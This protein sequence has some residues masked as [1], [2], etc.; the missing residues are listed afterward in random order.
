MSILT[1]IKQITS[2][3]I[4]RV[5]RLNKING[6]KKTIKS[7]RTRYSILMR[8]RLYSTIR[9]W[10]YRIWPSL[11]SIS[12]WSLMRWSALSSNSHLI[13]NIRNIFRQ[14]TAQI[15]PSSNRRRMRCET[16]Q[17]LFTLINGHNSSSRTESSV[18]HSKTVIPF[19]ILWMGT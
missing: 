14:Q 5:I 3:I 10:N 4:R 6:I 15:E 18:P 2:K 16:K 8:K 9:Q 17:R 19:S 7:K 13:Q 11:I 1:W 12:K